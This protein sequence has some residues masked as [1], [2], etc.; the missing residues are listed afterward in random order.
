ME[1]VQE[2]AVANATMGGG[3]Q[4]RWSDANYDGDEDF[5]VGGEG[6]PHLKQVLRM[7]R[8]VP[9]RWNSMYYIIK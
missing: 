2:D 6:Q 4:R 1:P 3:A 7:L 5:F 8:P 9:T